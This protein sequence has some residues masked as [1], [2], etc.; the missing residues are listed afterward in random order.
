LRG[1]RALCLLLGLF[2]A[3]ATAAEVPSELRGRL[4]VEVTS[5]EPLR[6]D[7]P[8]RAVLLR[9]RAGGSSL[10]QPEIRCGAFV[11]GTDQGLGWTRVVGLEQLAAESARAV[12]TLVPADAAHSECRCVAGAA[13]EA[14]ACAPW[15]SLENGRCVE[16]GERAEGSTAPPAARD[17][18]ASAL[19][20]S[21]SLAALRSQLEPGP[22]PK[23]DAAALCS[24]VDPAQLSELVSALVPEDRTVY[25]L[26]PWHRLDAADRS[27]FAHWADQCFGAA[28]IVDAE[29]GV[30]VE[31]STPRPAQPASAR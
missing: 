14:V 17:D 5:C 3:A 6:G 7:A 1:W 11:P 18:V 16:P 10:R 8:A 13:I 25:V 28:R 22:G 2:A 15:E 31:G 20:I 9:V 19:R 21:R 26:S 29:R 4:S 27:A 30:E 12:M 23:P 24:S